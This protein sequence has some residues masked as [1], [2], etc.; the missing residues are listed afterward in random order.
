VSVIGQPDYSRFVGGKG[1]LYRSAVIMRRRSAADAPPPESGE[2]SLPLERLAGS[3]FTFNGPDSMSGII[4][5]RRDLV[6]CGA[7]PS[8]SGFPAFWSEVTVSGGHRGSVVAVAE[9]AADAA[10]ID[11]RTLDLCRRFEPAA[12]EVEVVGWTGLRPGLPY[13]AARGLAQA[14]NL[15]SNG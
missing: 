11:C 13:I 2:P 5:L 12:R 3:R 14:L 15:A 8:E 10:A 1:P 9:G 4:A 7:I 6:R